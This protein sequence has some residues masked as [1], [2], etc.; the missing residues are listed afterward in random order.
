MLGMINR[1]LQKY[2]FVNGA[3]RVSAAFMEMSNV[4]PLRRLAPI[5]GAK[6]INDIF[7]VQIFAG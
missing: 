5:P 1:H 4:I 2:R 7:F 6:Y 3:I